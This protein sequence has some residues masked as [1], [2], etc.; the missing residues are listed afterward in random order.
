M[1]IQSK[2][3]GT[4]SKRNVGRVLHSGVL[5]KHGD[6]LLERFFV[7]RAGGMSDGGAAGMPVY[8]NPCLEYYEVATSDASEEEKSRSRAEDALS[9]TELTSTTGERGTGPP[10]GAMLLGVENCANFT[11]PKQGSGGSGLEGSM[12]GSGGLSFGSGSGSLLRLSGS[13]LG[14][15][16]GGMGEATPL[17]FSH[18]A[19]GGGRGH[20]RQSSA[21][22]YGGA[23]QPPY[24]I[25]LSGYA[26]DGTFE[27]Q[28]WLVEARTLVEFKQWVKV[29]TKAFRPHWHSDATHPNCEICG[30]SFSLFRRRHHCRACGVSVCNSHSTKRM[31]VSGYNRKVRV[32]DTCGGIE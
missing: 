14:V 32:C 20:S 7:L 17:P 29:L 8:H 9:W 15:G 25:S 24:C 4:K 21:D 23:L 27:S 26:S 2:A 13:G 3:K 11:S 6:H 5:V 10:R 22:L 18:R 12:G 16:Q 19:Q 30:K 1:S 31:L 28:S